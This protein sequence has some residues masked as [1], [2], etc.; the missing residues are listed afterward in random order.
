MLGVAIQITEILNS[1]NNCEWKQKL[2]KYMQ[3]TGS[4]IVAR[5]REDNQVLIKGFV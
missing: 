2:K 1:K 4:A 5:D 3:E